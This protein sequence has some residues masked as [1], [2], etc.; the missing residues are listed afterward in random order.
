[1]KKSAIS[2]FAI[3]LLS[4]ITNTSHAQYSNKINPFDGSVAKTVIKDGNN[5]YSKDGIQ[6]KIFDNKKGVQTGT[7]RYYTEDKLPA[8]VRNQVKAGYYD[9]NIFWV[10]EVTVGNKTVYMVKIKNESDTK[11]I[12]VMNGEMEVVEEFKNL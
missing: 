4:W 3:I 2:G 12:R 6:T 9:Y 8:D 5:S 11:T 10:T 7:I 1:M